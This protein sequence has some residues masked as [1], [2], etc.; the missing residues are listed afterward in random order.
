M[1]RALLFTAWI[2]VLGASVPG[3]APAGQAG[4]GQTPQVTFRL[5]TNYVEVDAFV[6]DKSG[7]FVR[8]LTAADFEVLED[9]RPQK[10]EAFS[11]VDLPFIT[12]VGPPADDYIEP[13]YISNEGGIEGRIYMILLDTNHISALRTPKL[14]QVLRRFVFDNV[15]AND[16]VAV[17]HVGRTDLSQ[18]FTSNKRLVLEA[19]DG[20]TGN[21]L[22]SP[23]LNKFDALVRMGD[24]PKGVLPVP[25]DMDAQERASV[26]AQSFDAIG[27]LGEYMAGIQG[28]RKTLLLVSEG[29]DIDLNDQIGPRPGTEVSPTDITERIDTAIFGNTS[30]EAALA[31]QVATEMQR[32][33][34]TATRAN[35]AVYSIDPRGLTDAAEL[36]IEA[37]GPPVGSTIL[38]TAALRRELRDSQQVLRSIAEQTGGRA[39]VGTNNF[40]DGFKQ[41][42]DDSSTYYV[43]GYRTTP[44]YD[45]K[46]HNITVRLTRPGL[47]VRARKGYHALKTRPA[48]VADVLHELLT[49]PM[50]MPGLTMRVSST[51]LR[52]PA[53]NGLVQFTLEFDKD[54]PFEDK[55][56]TFANRIEISYLAADLEGKTKAT[57]SKTL[58]MALKPDVREAM[59]N[60]GLRFATE[61][62]L[63]PGRYQIRLAAK[64]AVGGKAGSLFWDVV[65]PDFADEPLTMSEIV[66]SSVL[67]GASPTVHDATTLKAMLPVP[68]TTGRAFALE[69]VITVFAEVYDRAPAAHTVEVVTTV[70]TDDGIEVFRA[71]ETRESSA[72]N[73]ERAS[74]PYVAKIPLEDLAPGRF[75]VGVTA[76][77]STG[78]TVSREVRILIK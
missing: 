77:S 45:G 30:M 72:R 63:A 3:A 32:M 64:E 37:T 75:V 34:E 70:T 35:I 15:A 1:R 48:V 74:Y 61:L 10:V 73:A 28:R 21:K 67:A 50:A 16:K 39:I 24:D 43:L 56:G 6:T 42:V 25:R 27:R 26:A 71:E 17:V 69:D 33:I 2:V 62:A 58:D 23:A 49:S 51:I 65:V 40:D 41:I 54:L 31:S 36:A 19:I 57:A 66:L 53:T 60:G 18:D 44:K 5:E 78:G 55:G 38:P 59:G 13:G 47:E 8:D 9:G 46:F 76:T 22:R 52:G 29:L 14:K 68:P 12:A 4:A 7:R 20:F 11:L